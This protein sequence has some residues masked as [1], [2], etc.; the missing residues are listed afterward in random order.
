MARD[1]WGRQTNRA[2]RFFFYIRGHWLRMPPKM[3]TRHLWI[4]WRKGQRG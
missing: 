3:L 1:G 4:K 2:L